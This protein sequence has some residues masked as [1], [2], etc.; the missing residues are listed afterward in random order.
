MSKLLC[1]LFCLPILIGFS[2]P[3]EKGEY[4]TYILKKVD[5]ERKK[6]KEKEWWNKGVIMFAIN[7]LPRLGKITETEKQI[8]TT[9]S[10]NQKFTGRVYLPQSVGEI[11]PIPVTIFYHLV[12]DGKYAKT[13]VVS[14]GEK[15]PDNDW[16]SWVIDFPEYFEAEWENI[17]AGSHNCR[18]ECWAGY[19]E[20]ETTVWVDDKDKALGTTSEKKGKVKFL[21]S[22]DFTYINGETATKKV[23][24]ENDE[25]YNEGINDLP[26]DVPANWKESFYIKKPVYKKPLKPVVCNTIGCP[27]IEITTESIKYEQANDGINSWINITVKNTGKIKT[28]ETNVVFRGTDNESS[29]EF[30]HIQKA[31]PALLPGASVNIKFTLTNF[32]YRPDL[33]NYQIILDY[34]NNIQGNEDNSVYSIN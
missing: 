14:S 23:N 22:G 8:I 21:A 33:I 32:F 7:D 4:H 15:M 6:T 17:S 1:I 13:K 27:A 34:D 2:Q 24:E 26:K 9:V 16:C 11:Q 12:I 18:V 19:A 29:K 20:N 10:A 28:C 25:F 31:V 5:A 3:Q 30:S